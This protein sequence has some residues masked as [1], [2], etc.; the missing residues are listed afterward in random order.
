MIA[1]FNEILVMMLT[2]E[3]FMEGIQNSLYCSGEHE[4]LSI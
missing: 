3:E 4:H 2:E 1:Y